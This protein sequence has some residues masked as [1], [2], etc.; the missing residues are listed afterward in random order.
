MV[1]N[2][3]TVLVIFLLSPLPCTLN[4][5]PCCVIMS[6]SQYSDFTL[7]IYDW[8]VDDINYLASSSLLDL[9]P[10]LSSSKQAFEAFNK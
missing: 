3:I 10:E 9:T 5:Y 7:S 4:I 6:Q 2:T 1:R 8:D